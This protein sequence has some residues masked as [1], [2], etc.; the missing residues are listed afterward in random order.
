M[1]N[2][3][4]AFLV[5]LLGAA[6]LAQSPKPAAGGVVA[7]SEGGGTVRLLWVP[8]ADHVP[9]G[10]WRIQD[11]KGKVLDRV[12]MGD[13]AALAGLPK[14][15]ADQVRTIQKGLREAPTPN[16]RKLALLA[17]FVEAGQSFEVGRALGLA[18][19][20]K[21]LPAGRRTFVI[22]GLDASG[23]PEATRFTSGPVDPSQPS[24]LP[25]QVPGLQAALDGRGVALSWSPVAA[26]PIPVMDY[27]VSRDG[28]PLTT[29]PFI[30][31]ASWKA[32]TSQFQDREASLEAEH[33]FEVTAVDI[34]GRKGPASSVRV[35]LPD[36]AALEPPAGFKAEAGP[37]RILLSWAPPKS[38][39]VTG[40]V[41]E[42]A[43]LREG[44]W[45][46]LSRKSLEPGATRYEDA[47][48]VYYYRIHTLNSK[49]EPGFPSMVAS[50][51]AKAGKAIEAPAGLAVQDGTSRV[52]LTWNPASR[53]IAGYLVERRVGSNHAWARL[54]ANLVD[55]PRYDDYLGEDASGGFQYRVTAVDFDS[56]MSSS[57]PVSVVREDRSAPRVPHLMQAVGNF[58]KVLLRFRPA[59]P[60]ER[61][62]GYLVLR[63]QPD[64]KD[65]LVIGD[66]LPGT[67][68]EFT[69]AWVKP[70]Q[71]YRYRLLALAAN[72][73]RSEPSLQLEVLV[74]A[75]IV[76][77]P[78]RPV[79]AYSAKP[80]ARVVFTFPEPPEG[81]VYFLHRKTGDRRDWLQIQGPLEGTEARDVNPPSAGKVL[82]RLHAQSVDGTASHSGES[83]E[84]VIP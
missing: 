22:A 24:P 6:A 1:L 37:G 69:D 13:E 38:R 11:D 48:T 8:P 75:P 46:G 72:S 9:A 19:T 43:H 5:S 79:P 57:E 28:T 14:A 23:A 83:V 17:A 54:N 66:P 74:G 49:G 81:V 67:A 15:K 18:T 64:L 4:N 12:A 7:C 2:L 61:T 21:G 26:A 70:G 42:R 82:Y 65:E 33:T 56:S 31:G 76:D 20:L 55:E 47:G 30:L 51:Q 45:E 41:I 27:R 36:P 34:F 60:A 35:Y 59:P 44:P 68:T 73:M 78:P 62:T 77:A 50:A 58:G 3:R 63:T 80:F 53:P 25:P 39:Y 40:F 29:G 32:G 52:R 84:V 10:G 16:D 71:V